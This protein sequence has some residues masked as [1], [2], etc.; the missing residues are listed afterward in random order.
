MFPVAQGATRVHSLQMFGH[1]VDTLR[2]APQEGAMPWKETNAMLERKQFI[3]D[4]ESGHWPMTELCD[5]FGVSRTTAYK[6]L[7]RYQPGRGSSLQDR[8]RAPRSCP[9]KTPEHIVRLILEESD[10]YRWGARKLHNLLS[11]RHPNLELPAI[12]TFFDILKRHGRVTRRRRR[13]RWK[14]PGAVPLRTSEPNQVWTVDFKGQFKMGDRVYCYPLTVAD[15][16]SRYLLC[17][18][19]LLSVETSGTK[20]AFLQLFRDVGLPEAI[21]SDNGTPFASRGIH[22]LCALNVWWMKLGII[23]QRIEPASPQQNAAHERMHRTLKDKTA[24]PPAANL[25]SQQRWFNRFR[26]EYNEVRPHEGIDDDRPADRWRP[27]PRPYPNK[28]Q[29]PV[30]PN[31][32]EVRKVSRQG[33][34]RIHHHQ[35]FLSN[36]LQGEYIGLEEIDDGLWNI[37]YY[38]TLLGRI[39]QASGK[40]TGAHAVQNSP[41]GHKK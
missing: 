8:S 19:G 20:A 34:F 41:R 14:H 7:G 2:F 17:C 26:E 36:A 30:Y 15:H 28:I 21:R 40:L 23:H 22:G 31:H 11:K 24:K 10:R 33:A 32:F 12:S 16:F 13:T 18:K 9:H 6:W 5:R 4:Y 37:V 39:D 29:P 27:S 25:K 1:M 3:E 35:Q 38:D